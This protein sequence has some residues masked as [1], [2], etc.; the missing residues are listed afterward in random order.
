MGQLVPWLVG[1]GLTGLVLGLSNLVARLFLRLHADAIASE[2]RRA[3]EVTAAER[4]RADEAVA[5]SEALERRV[6]IKDDQMALL[7]GRVKEPTA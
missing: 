5:R 4:R 6:E 1:G 7:L 3:D 2:Q